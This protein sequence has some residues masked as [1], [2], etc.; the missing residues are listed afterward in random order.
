MIFERIQH[1][2]RPNEKADGYLKKNTNSPI[3]IKFDGARRLALETGR[4]R[5]LVAGALFTM[6]FAIFCRNIDQ[7]IDLYF[8]VLKISIA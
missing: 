5:L 8:R 4:N 7:N 6:A 2:F 3:H 1:P